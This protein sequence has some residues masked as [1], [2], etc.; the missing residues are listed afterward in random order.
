MQKYTYICFQRA[1]RKKFLGVRKWCNANDLP[2]IKQ[3]HICWKICK[4]R[5]HVI[6]IFKRVEIRK[7]SEVF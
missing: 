4:L 5:K 6:S 3:K 1:S 2:D 7:M